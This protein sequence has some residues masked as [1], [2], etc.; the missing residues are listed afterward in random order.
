ML[1]YKKMAIFLILAI[2]F[3]AIDRFFKI[4]ALKYL[5]DDSFNIVGN[6]VKFSF[7]KN[8]NIAFS[9]PINS[10]ILLFL[11]FIIITFL[12]IY[13]LILIKKKDAYR[14]VLLAIVIISAINNILD[15][16]KWGYVVDY[17]E[18]KY[19]TVFN[20]AD[21]M[22]VISS[23]LL[24]IYNYKQAKNENFNRPRND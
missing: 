10:N 6:I 7:A 24:I 16:I 13:L 15:R 8:Y 9:L 11:L 14:T 17:I 2:F 22:I 18:V 3:N 19:F 21:A 23:F 12:I 4:Y 20:L 1:K 5:H